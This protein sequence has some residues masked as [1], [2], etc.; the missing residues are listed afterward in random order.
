MSHPDTCNICPPQVKWVTNVACSCRTDCADKKAA[1][2]NR[3]R[4]FA[5]ELGNADQAQDLLPGFTIDDPQQFVSG[6]RRGIFRICD[7]IEFSSCLHLDW[8]GSVGSPIGRAEG[9]WRG[10]NDCLK[11]YNHLLRLQEMAATTA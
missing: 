3:W 7:E 8:S 9:V 4:A 6:Y 2:L 10:E 11:A 1:F 5:N